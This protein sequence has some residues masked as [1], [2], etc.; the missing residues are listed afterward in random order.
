V[1]EQQLILGPPG[2]GKTH[3]L[4]SIMEDELA[5]GIRPDRI[6]FLSFT[7]RAADEARSRAMA[8]FSFTKED[9]PWFRTLHSLAYS[10]L[11]LRRDEVM[12]PKQYREVG[13]LLGLEFSTKLDIEEGVPSSRFNGDRYTFLAGYAMAKCVPFEDAW[14]SCS[15]DDLNWWEFRRFL[16]TM[17]EYKQAKGVFDFTDMLC[18]PQAPLDVDVV[19]IDEAQDLSTLQWQYVKRVV[20]PHARRVY[21]AGDDDQAIFQW[22]GADVRHFQALDGEQTVLSQSHRV[23]VA[24]HRVAEGIASGIT[25]RYRKEYRPKADQGSVEHHLSLDSVD[26]SAP[27]SWYLLARNSHLLPR[28]TALVRDQGLPYSLR[29]ESV[30]DPR[31]VRAIRA[32]ELKRK[33]G[34]P[35]ADD[36]AIVQTL[37]PKR[38]VTGLIWHEA[39]TKI[40]LIDREWYIGILRRGESLTKQPRINVATIHSVKGGEADNTLLMTD[41]SARSWSGYQMDPDGEHRVWYVGATR[42][43]NALHVVQPQTRMAFDM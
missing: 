41:M 13:A 3:Y 11:G 34:S 20:T 29:G 18:E 26:L 42:A 35:D 16:E 31:H 27:G 10:R 32:W 33:G 24:V 22:S 38:D 39:L 40:P 17:A 9:L 37:I 21:V 19:I 14:R 28:L 15:D 12:Q 8:K 4:L 25:S 6:A 43:K 5:T 2:T 7:R 36:W 23:P 30:I 1:R